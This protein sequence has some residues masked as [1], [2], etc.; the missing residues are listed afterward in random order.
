MIKVIAMT[1][2]PPILIIDDEEGSRFLLDDILSDNYSVFTACSSNEAFE[3]LK[4]HTF[5]IVVTDIRMPGEFDGIGILKYIRKNYPSSV[6]ILIT[7]HGD[8]ET[9]IEAVR[10]GAFDYLEKPF[11]EQAF[12]I[13]IERAQ[14]HFEMK[15]KLKESEAQRIIASKLAS[16][17]LLAAGVAHEINNPLAIIKGNLD[18][19]RKKIS[20]ID[21]CDEDILRSLKT[22]DDS[23]DRIITIVNSLRTYAHTNEEVVESI[24][25]HSIIENSFNLV[26]HLFNNDSV[27]IDRSYGAKSH[28]VRG[29]TGKIQQVIINLLNN[30]KDALEGVE[31]AEIKVTTE[32]TNKEIL[33]KV[34]DNG[35][36][37][38]KQHLEKLF[39]TFFTTKPIGKGTGLGLGICKSI[40]EGMGG[41]IEIDS[42]FNKGTSVNI[43]L[44]I[45]DKKEVQ[46]DDNTSTEES[47]KKLKGKILLVDDED[48]LREI[49]AEYLDEFGYEVEEATNGK[50]AL[51]MISKQKYDYLITDLKMPLMNGQ[52]LI[53]SIKAKKIS[54]GKIVIMTGGFISNNIKEDEKTLSKKVDGSLA[55][56]FSQQELYDVLNNM[57]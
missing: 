52:E 29:N 7:G 20:K 24:N 16:I 10:N 42:V 21:N 45:S 3:I 11:S 32:N 33:I 53:E 50:E 43:K 18:R 49:I 57:D 1:G 46:T 25:I 56:P 8:K 38:E 55:K 37:I 4:K 26:E 39:D 47:Y 5:N 13:A 36:G 23:I 17:G 44:P 35:T 41:N 51:N 48:E 2:L 19:L 15:N 34:V 14:D 22:Q 9:V 28:I 40:I 54:I 6:V 31:G 27:I 30:A 12:I